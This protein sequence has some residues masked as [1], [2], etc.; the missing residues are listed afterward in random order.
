[1]E[2]LY[3][4]SARKSENKQLLL[5]ILKQSGVFLKARSLDMSDVASVTHY[6]FLLNIT[7]PQ[8]YKMLVKYV[9]DMNFG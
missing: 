4:F 9:I 3:V 6:L 5:L 1:M 7:S 2:L 8:F